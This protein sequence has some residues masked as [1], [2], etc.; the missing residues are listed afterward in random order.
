MV[1]KTYNA[2]PGLSN[3]W[4]SLFGVNPG[5][6]PENILTLQGT[7]RTITWETGILEMGGLMT[8]K[9]RTDKNDPTLKNIKIEKAGINEG[10]TLF[11]SGSGGVDPN[12][13]DGGWHAVKIKNMN[14]VTVAFDGH[15][16]TGFLKKLKVRLDKDG[17]TGAPIV[18]E[19]KLKIKGE[20]SAPDTKKSFVNSVTVNVPETVVTAIAGV[21]YEEKIKAN[22]HV[23]SGQ[24]KA[25]YERESGAE[26]EDIATSSL[27]DGNNN[28]LT[29]RKGACIVEEEETPPTPKTASVL[30]IT[31]DP[32]FINRVDFVVETPWLSDP[33]LALYI[34]ITGLNGEFRLHGEQTVPLSD[35]TVIA[36]DA[37][38]TQVSTAWTTDTAGIVGG[39]VFTVCVTVVRLPGMTPEGPES[40]FDFG[41]F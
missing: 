13:A 24:I 20:T 41:P 17:T 38:L 6:S 34:K 9:V 1:L 2:D 28:Q 25:K 31:F 15:T 10:T 27:L 14:N 35:M 32:F 18:K 29:V 19:F 37:S 5:T 33:D 4:N 16:V 40:C 30:N 21:E 11:I 39:E 3:M 23:L 26:T 7:D 22:P 8:I 36:G 12:L